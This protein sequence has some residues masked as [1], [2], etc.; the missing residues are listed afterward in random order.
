MPKKSP[1]QKAEEER[2]YW[3]QVVQPIAKNSNHF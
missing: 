1:E 2:R 3:L